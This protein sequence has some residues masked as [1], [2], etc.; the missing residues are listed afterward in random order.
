[1]KLDEKKLHARWWIH[2]TLTHRSTQAKNMM[3]SKQMDIS[4]GKEANVC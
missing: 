2:P 3:E 4:F 1:M